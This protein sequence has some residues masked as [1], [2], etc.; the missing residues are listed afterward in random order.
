MIESENEIIPPAGSIRSRRDNTYRYMSI[1]KF[2][3][4]DIERGRRTYWRGVDCEGDPKNGLTIYLN[5][6][7][8]PVCDLCKYQMKCM[9]ITGET[10]SRF[11]MKEE[12]EDI[13]RESLHRWI[14]DNRTKY[15]IE[16]INER[17]V[18]D[19]G[20]FSD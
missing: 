10:D 9:F 12:F 5:E 17:Y 3:K 18:I 4:Y 6:K 2:L 1:N 7:Y 11:E 20:M 15:K 13:N 19:K 14:A 16:T 8:I